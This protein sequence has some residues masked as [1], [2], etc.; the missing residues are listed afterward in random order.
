MD[1]TIAFARSVK[2]E[3]LSSSYDEN[4]QKLITAGLLLNSSKINVK[5]STFLAFKTEISSCAQFVYLSLKNL[6][7]LDCF[8]NYKRSEKFKKNLYYYVNVE[9]KRIFD[10]LKE[11]EINIEQKDKLKNSIKSKNFKYLLI[12]LFLGSGSINNPFS[13]KTSYFLEISFNNENDADL[14]MKKLNSF[15]NEKTMT[16]KKI[17]RR[18]KYIIYLKKSDQISVF[19]SYIG[20]T[21]CMFEFENA[22]IEKDDLNIINRLSICDT[23]NFKKTMSVSKKDIDAIN[24]L[25]EYKPIN[26]FD[27]KTQT[28]IE[29]RKKYPEMN[30]REISETITNNYNIPITKSGVVHILMSLRNQAEDYKKKN[31]GT[32][33]KK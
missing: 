18:D 10:V 4:K 19:L 6:F 5:G 11:L 25:L 16:F 15:K 29:V 24:Y 20:A 26:L 17:K 7:K 3:L 23:S 31:N 13:K 32:L 8:L 27:K 22:R 12:G 9:D 33:Y 2:E 1:Q 28:V 21:S 30:L 14:I